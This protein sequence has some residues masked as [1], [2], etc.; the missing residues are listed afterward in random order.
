[1]SF[2]ISFS[3]AMVPASTIVSRRLS[4]RGLSATA[5]LHSAVF[6][7]MFIPNR[8]YSLTENNF[9]L[10]LIPRQWLNGKPLKSEVFFVR[11]HVAGCLILAAAIY[12]SAQQNC[13]VF[14]KERGYGRDQPDLFRAIFSQRSL[15]S[16][17][18]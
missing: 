16:A 10:D 9:I 4:N 5:P 6:V 8:N 13:A 12:R 18:G 3:L 14:F 7:H 15:T 1:M 17:H 2:L 11:S